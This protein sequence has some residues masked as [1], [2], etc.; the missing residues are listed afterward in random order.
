[1]PTIAHLSDT[2]GATKRSNFSLVLILG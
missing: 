2:F 1:M